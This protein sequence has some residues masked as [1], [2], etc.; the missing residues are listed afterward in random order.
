MVKLTAHPAHMPFLEAF[1]DI[2]NA[3]DARQAKLKTRLEHEI[4]ALCL[5]RGTNDPDVVAEAKVRV[6]LLVDVC[7][8]TRSGGAAEFMRSRQ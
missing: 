6:Q 5:A 7:N 4:E 1:V 2:I 8:W 3:P